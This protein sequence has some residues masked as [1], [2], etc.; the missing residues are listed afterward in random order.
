M[1]TRTT[2]EINGGT[3]ILY[4]KVRKMRELKSKEKEIYQFITD[5]ALK[6]NYLPSI[7]EIGDGVN[8]KSTSSVFA[9]LEDMQSK[10]Y[11]KREWSSTR[12]SVKG[13]RYV[14]EDGY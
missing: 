8:L 9:Y 7:R 2:Q 3:F 5:F 6:N 13:L 1:Q 4:V 14:K 12:Y 11:I 10:G